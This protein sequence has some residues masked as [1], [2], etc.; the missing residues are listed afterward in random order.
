MVSLHDPDN[1]L[2]AGMLSYLNESR[3]ID[4]SK[5]LKELDIQLQYPD[6]ETGL[7]QALAATLT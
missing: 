7:E 3:R 2:S 6:L 4:N 1:G 5:V